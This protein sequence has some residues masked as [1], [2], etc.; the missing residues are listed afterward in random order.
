MADRL[1][2]HLDKTLLTFLPKKLQCDELFERHPDGTLNA[3]G[4][5][6]TYESSTRLLSFKVM[7][8]EGSNQLAISLNFI[9][10][11]PLAEEKT[12]LGE[13]RYRAVFSL[14]EWALSRGRS[15]EYEKYT[16]Q[17]KNEGDEKFIDR[18]WSWLQNLLRNELRDVTEGRVWE[19]FLLFLDRSDQ[20]EFYS[21]KKNRRGK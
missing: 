8:I 3:R 19:N 12:H 1:G 10:V 11:D 2:N 21:H 13:S 15:E 14:G 5:K 7:T 17:Q 20:V 9:N 18:F 4:V 6:V 16:C